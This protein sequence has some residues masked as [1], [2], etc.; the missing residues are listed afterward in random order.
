[1]G[2]CENLSTIRFPVIVKMANADGLLVFAKDELSDELY[3]E[4]KN[5]S[6]KKIITCCWFILCLVG[7]LICSSRLS[8]NERVGPPIVQQLKG[9]PA[10]I[11]RYY[12][13]LRLLQLLPGK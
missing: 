3:E 12:Y 13:Q 4:A 7:V 1:M 9:S 5:Y 8:T 11:P 2:L 10:L 6:R